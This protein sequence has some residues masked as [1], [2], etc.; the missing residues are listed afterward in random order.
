M[1]RRKFLKIAGSG[2]T[3]SPWLAQLVIAADDSTA[4][5]GVLDDSTNAAIR[6]LFESNSEEALAL[7]ETVFRKCILEKIMPPMRL[8]TTVCNRPLPY[9]AVLM[10]IPG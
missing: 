5:G 6:S 2:I 7:T 10:G 1:K 9:S 8:T 3:L 4:D